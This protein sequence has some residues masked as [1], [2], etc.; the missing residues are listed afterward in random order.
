MLLKYQNIVVNYKVPQDKKTIF[1]KAI[2]LSGGENIHY[3]NKLCQR[4][5]TYFIIN[6]RQ[7]R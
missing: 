7:L 2:E 5:S 4:N 3:L 6:L 1:Y